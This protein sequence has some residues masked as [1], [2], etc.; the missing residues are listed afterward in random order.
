MSINNSGSKEK[1][2][3][4]AFVATKEIQ[5]ALAKYA[6]E[7]ERSVSWIIRKALEAYLKIEPKSKK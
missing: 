3:T 6:K 4:I 7:Q 5:A 1:G 2:P